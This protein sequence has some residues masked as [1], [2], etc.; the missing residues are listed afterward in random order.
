MR[1]AFKITGCVLIAAACALA[2]PKPPTPKLKLVEVSRIWSQAPHNAF[3]DL[4]R[5]KNRWFCVFRE[6]SSHVSPDG[7]IRVLSSSDGTNWASASLIATQYGD[8]RNPKLSITTDERLMLTAVEAY[9][10]QEWVRHQTFV[11]LSLDGRN[12]GSRV[13]IGDPNMWLGQVAWH[14]RRA[15]SLGYSTTRDHFIRMYTATDGISF[16]PHGEV[17][18]NKSFPSEASLLFESNDAALCVLRRE[19]ADPKEGA[20]LLGTSQPPYRGWSWRSLGVRIGGPNMIQLPDERVVVAARLYDGRE[21][22]SLCWL[23][24]DSGILDEF[25]TLPSG[26]DSSYPGLV[27]YDGLLWISYYSSHEGKASIYLAKVQIPPLR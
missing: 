13:K 22:T 16:Q 14:N 1:L 11:W 19:D 12:W 6:G 23:D 7:A 25:L 17:M 27:Y 21:R 18:L 24:A 2:A 8:L 9:P 20:A 3:T 15:Y 26:G 4:I 10:A 5:Y